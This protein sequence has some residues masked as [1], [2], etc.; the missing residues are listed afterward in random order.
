MPNGIRRVLPVAHREETTWLSP[1]RSCRLA[2]ARAHESPLD[3]AVAVTAPDGLHV[4]IDSEAMAQAVYLFQPVFRLRWVHRGDLVVIRSNAAARRLP[5][6]DEIHEGVAASTVFVDFDLA[7]PPPT[8]RG[9]RGARR[10]TPS[11]GAG[12]REGQPVLVHFDVATFRVDDLILQVSVDHTMITLLAGADARFRAM[13]EASGDTLAL[14]AVDPA[15]RPAR[16]GLRQP[17]CTPLQPGI[18]IA[19]RSRRR[20]PSGGRCGRTAPHHSAR[21]VAAQQRRPQPSCRR[22][23]DV[24]ADRRRPGDV[25]GARDHIRGDRPR[26]ARTQRARAGVPWCRIVR[27]DRRLRAALRW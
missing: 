11:S 8:W 22:R 6:A 15:A 14:L 18:E 17:G 2:S 20:G 23:G 19:N 7:P 26:R 12:M 25:R 4:F 21:S 3:D 9:A 13:A 10:R 16:R 5:L 27:H 1:A 24:H